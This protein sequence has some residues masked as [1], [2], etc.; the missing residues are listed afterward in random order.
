[1]EDKLAKLGPILDKLKRLDPKT[2][3]KL[4]SMI[5]QSTEVS[6]S[7]SFLQQDVLPSYGSQKSASPEEALAK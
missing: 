1:M 6:S 2:F 7:K 4:N 5:S 3:G